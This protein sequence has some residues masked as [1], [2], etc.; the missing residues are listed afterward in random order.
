M[1]TTTVI[2]Q[3]FMS[4]VML[5]VF[6]YRSTLTIRE[7]VR[8]KGGW[9]ALDYFVNF[10]LFAASVLAFIAAGLEAGRSVP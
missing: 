4:I 8:I 5:I 2:S 6:I 3:F 1:D 9:F 10:I 7:A